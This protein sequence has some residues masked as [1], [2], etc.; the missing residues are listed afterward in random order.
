MTFVGVD[1][2]TVLEKR[3]SAQRRD[4]RP[5]TPGNMLMPT[6]FGIGALGKPPC[7]I[8]CAV[9]Q[10]RHSPANRPRAAM[11]RSAYNHMV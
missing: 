6:G 10:K 3:F 8:I 9:T 1:G 7:R 11:P 4:K 5:Y 2:P